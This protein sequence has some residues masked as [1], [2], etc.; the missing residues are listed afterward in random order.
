M[1]PVTTESRTRPN[2]RDGIA[3]STVAVVQ[4]GARLHYALARAL[5]RAGALDR[6]FT[7]CFARPGGYQH[8][9]AR[10]LSWI[11][12]ALGR[13]MTGR[14]CSEL[15][16]AQVITNPW[17][18]VRQRRARNRHKLAVDYYR[19]CARQVESWVRAE[20][21]GNAAA[22]AGYIRNVEPALFQLAREQGLLTLGDQMIAPAAVEL[23]QA[24]LQAERWPRWQ[25]APADA[26]LNA[27][28]QWEQ[29]TW[30]HLDHVLCA[31]DFVRD[32]LL[33]QGVEARR[34][35]VLP[36]PIDSDAIA[37]VDRSRR[38]GPVTVGFVG[39]VS[40]RKG[41]PYFLQVADR[42]DPK[43]VRFA[44]VGDVAVSRKALAAHTGNVQVVGRVGRAEVQSW[45]ARFDTI[46]FPTTSRHKATTCT[47]S[48]RPAITTTARA[49]PIPRSAT[50][51]AP[52][53][54]SIASPPPASANDPWSAA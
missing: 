33:A 16:D 34:I 18:A 49:P 44:M 11:Y 4:D 48:A 10:M 42:F 32:G 46:L 23:E 39:A 2:R 27:Y 36:Y 20:G 40:L 6:M 1:T 35:S 9:A 15:D 37:P 14:H 52:A 51:P 8:T 28:R 7:E 50:K 30:T 25:T 3:A 22:V 19:W 12:P 13:D 24:H 53:S 21:F 47:C 5:Y 17:L 45:L 29:Q 26:Q 43:Q 38:T 54:I 41:V 31:S